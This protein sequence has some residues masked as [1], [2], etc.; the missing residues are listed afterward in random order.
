MKYNLRSLYLC[1]DEMERALKFY[2][3]SGWDYLRIK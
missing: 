2:G 1:A 3:D